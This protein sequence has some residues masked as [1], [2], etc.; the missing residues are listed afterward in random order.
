M[1]TYLLPENGTFYKANLHSHSTVSDGRWTPE[2]IKRRYMEQGYSVVAYTDHHIL[3]PHNE[4]TDERF[5]A[6]NGLEIGAIDGAP[7]KRRKNCDFCLIALSPDITERPLWD[8]TGTPPDE[9]G[10]YVL[11]RFEPDFVNA[12]LADARRM[13]FFV[14]YNHP[15]WSLADYGDYIRYDGM[16]AMEI[17]NYGCVALGYDEHNARIYNDLLRAG[18]RLY[19]VAA[20]DNHNK[21][22]DSFGGFTMIK[23]EA[24][25]YTQI[26]AALQKGHFY[27]S[28]GPTIGSLYYEDG[29]VY[30]RTSPA[31][32]IRITKP[33]RSA[34]LRREPGKTVTEACFDVSPDDGYFFITVIGP[35]GSKAYTN[36]CFTDDL[37]R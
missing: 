12:V 34:G 20:D 26:T 7:K 21:A 15:T 36:A 37:I 19:C 3:A 17:C 31:Q 9:L 23:A 8:L 27:A 18:K 35:D 32:A 22:D 10:R 5:V 6:L 24:L 14:T 30:I 29:K 33:I 25:T 1:R 2:E 13:G 11:M 16:H 4:L 28:E